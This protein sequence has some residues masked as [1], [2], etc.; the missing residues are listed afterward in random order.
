MLVLGEREVAGNTVAVRKRRSGDVGTM[1]IDE[2]VCQVKK[3]IDTKSLT[4]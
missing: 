1:S 3:E 2:F 4:T